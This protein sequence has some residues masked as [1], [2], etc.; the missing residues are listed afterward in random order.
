MEKMLRRLIGEDIDIIITGDSTPARVKA[1]PSQMEQI[2]MNL[3]VNARDAMPQGGRL[4]IQTTNADL[5]ET[6]S[7]QHAG[8]KPGRY[9]TLSFSDTGDGMDKE[10]QARIFEPFFTTK[11][12]GKGTGLGLSTVYGIVKQNGGYIS[13]YS[14]PG[15]GSTFKIHLPQAEG[16]AQSTKTVETSEILPRGSETILLV[17]DEEAL[18]TLARNCLES[19]GYCVLEA[20]DGKAAMAR[21]GEHT[22]PIQLLLTDIIMPG[23]NGRDLANRMTALHAEMK[24]IYMSGY[25]NDLIAQYG[26]LDPETLLLE[27]PFTLR[28][29]L[30]KVHQA[31]RTLAKATAAGGSC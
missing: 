7:R 31:L 11:E 17:E 8:F 3:A 18:R 14:E 5:D 25:S 9:V 30:T 6:Y 27:K 20:A 1:D 19:H 16:T 10:T 15:Q 24:V 26:V 4:L 13:V 28:A 22:G 2:L 21:A 29:L 23:M 12:P